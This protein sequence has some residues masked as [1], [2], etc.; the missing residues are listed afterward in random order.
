MRMEDFKKL[1]FKPYTDEYIDEDGP[2][3][4]YE[5]IIEFSS[6][7]KMTIQYGEWE[8]EDKGD[9]VNTFSWFWRDDDVYPYAMGTDGEGEL[10]NIDDLIE[11]INLLES[12]YKK[13]LEK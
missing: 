4:L 9:G 12:N 5:T 3:F 11:T 2:Y 10:E 7:G 1:T 6:T 8:G 13:F